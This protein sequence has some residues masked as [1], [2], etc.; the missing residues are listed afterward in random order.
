MRGLYLLLAIASA[1]TMK[2]HP[3]T[4]VVG[5]L[6]SMQKELTEE[7]AKDSKTNHKTNCALSASIENSNKMI[8]QAQAQITQADASKDASHKAV[9]G[10]K[11]AADNS[12]AAAKEAKNNWMRTMKQA[13][14]SAK[15][16][17]DEIADLT[18]TAAGLKN[19]LTVLRGESLLQAPQLNHV[20][21]QL[22]LIAQKMSPSAQGVSQVVSFC[23]SGT[24][25][26]G[27]IIGTL[28]T[29]KEGAE[30]D[31][32]NTK[33]KAAATS[34][35]NNELASGYQ[36]EVKAAESQLETANR[37][38]GEAQADLGD[39]V[40]M[41]ADATAALR[42]NTKARDEAQ[43]SVKKANEDFNERQMAR[44]TEQQGVADT[45]GILSGD[46]VRQ[47]TRS[48]VGFVQMASELQKA[49]P[50]ALS[51]I[52]AKLGAGNIGK[53]VG[54][55]KENIKTLEKDGQNDRDK[56]Q[57]CKADFEKH[58]AQLKMDETNLSEAKGQ[59]EEASA[60]VAELTA[61]IRDTNNE[62]VDMQRNQESNTAARAESNA[63]NHE[64][65]Q[66]QQ[67]TANT[68][69]SAINRMKTVF[70]S[71]SNAV[72]DRSLLQ[73]DQN[74]GGN[75]VITMLQKI[76][77]EADGNIKAIVHSEED[78]AAAYHSFMDDTTRAIEDAEGAVA[79]AEIKKG[80]QET[81]RNQAA[82]DETSYT[83]ATSTSVDNVQNTSKEC[84][85]FLNNDVF[86]AGQRD[87]DNEI[88]NLNDAL[89]TIQTMKIR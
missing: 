13:N 82:S 32:S 5:L 80:G 56:R 25:G 52:A 21:Q 58:S 57:R 23:E 65:M 60:A 84:K 4:R 41:L 69:K 75:K 68:L 8:A 34:K 55:I 33:D 47:N 73:R 14:D 78:E 20:K 81:N 28:V 35:E 9:I 53:V 2:E 54:A 24:Q 42:A 86:E 16:S 37:K 62:K 85:Y 89:T 63:E 26:T 27:E 39:A 29:M 30:E 1:M 43:A 72:E 40:S 50:T 74:A 79:A 64:N 46:D 51:L 7:G 17:Q 3:L 38:G 83:D 12:A 44:A 88:S 11:Q 31:L 67:I 18:S 59:K 19:A 61:S 66:A 45:I 71:E 48:T 10:F 6:K 15:E 22:S 76:K 87:R 70:E 77:D 49:S 36:E